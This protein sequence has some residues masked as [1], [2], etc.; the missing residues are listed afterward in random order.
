VVDRG[1]DGSTP[2]RLRSL[3]AH[4]AAAVCLSRCSFVTPIR[5]SE[6][7]IPHSAFIIPIEFTHSYLVLNAN[8]T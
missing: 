5:H 7:I 2:Q 4:R 1:A 8:V 3:A 6:F